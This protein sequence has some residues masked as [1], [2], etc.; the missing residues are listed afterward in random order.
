MEGLS[1]WALLQLWES[2]LERHPIDRGLLL[3]AY[4]LPG[5]SLEQLRRLTVGQRNERVLELRRRTMGSKMSCYAVCPHCGESLE[6]SLDSSMF[7]AQAVE[8][9]AGEIAIE[10][11]RIAYRLPNSSDL[12]AAASQRDLTAARDVLLKRCVTRA[13]REDQIVDA[14]KLPQTV[15]TELGNVISQHDPLAEISLNLRCGSCAGE[16]AILLDI[17]AFFWKEMSARAY[18]LMEDVHLLASSYGWHEKDIL[19]MSP[20][21]RAYYLSLRA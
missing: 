7:A 20:T 17:V 6:F 18:R 21:R 5:Y 1:D 3:L 4:T 14:L 10:D 12:G 8:A 2:G 13:M 11:Y 9:F 16:W 19:S 15:I